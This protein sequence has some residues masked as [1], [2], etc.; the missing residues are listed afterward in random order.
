[1][2]KTPECLGVND[3]V[4]VS[5]IDSTD[6]TLFLLPISPLLFVTE[7]SIGTK[8]LMLS[9]LDFLSDIHIFTSGFPPQ[10]SEASQFIVL[11][12]FWKTFFILIKI[13]H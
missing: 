5:L 13:L 6:I 4:P 8:D 3:P 2:L 12:N 10:N 7:G 1:M 9:F 11:Q